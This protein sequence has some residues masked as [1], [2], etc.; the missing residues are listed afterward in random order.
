V[1]E[2]APFDP[3]AALAVL[4]RYTPPS[5]A[6]LLHA[7]ADRPDVFAGAV[8]I[9]HGG[10]KI[11]LP[12]GAI[13]DCIYNVDGPPSARR[14]QMLYIDPNAPPPPPDPFALER[15]PLDFIDETMPIGPLGGPSFETIAAGILEPLNGADDVLAGGAATIADLDVGAGLDDGSDSSLSDAMDGNAATRAAIDNDN[16]AD[17]ID[18]TNNHSAEISSGQHDYVEP[19]VPDAPVPD[20]GNPPD[21][22]NPPPDGPPPA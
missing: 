15:G 20:P 12:D 4:V 1:P 3:G 19:P 17:V 21:D 22:G 6:N 10:D 14:W 8:P 16:P 5:G 9:G 2:L 13:W 11:Q 7:L 18:A